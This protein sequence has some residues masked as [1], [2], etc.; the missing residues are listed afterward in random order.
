M[1][2][3]PDANNVTD[4]VDNSIASTS[5]SPTA[6]PTKNTSEVTRDIDTNSDRDDD[7]DSESEKPT[8]RQRGGR[9]GW[10]VLSLLATFVVDM[11]EGMGV[12]L[13]EQEGFGLVKQCFQAAAEREITVGDGVHVYVISKTSTKPRTT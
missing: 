3:I 10:N 11:G 2:R 8:G 4:V 6:P 12:L 13:S 1:H 7:K 9:G 5:T